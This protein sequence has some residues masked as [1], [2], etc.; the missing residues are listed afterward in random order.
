[1]RIK[2]CT[3]QTLMFGVYMAMNSRI[4]DPINV[5]KNIEKNM[6]EHID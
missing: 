1:M 6:F 3:E 5:R 2:I 4:F